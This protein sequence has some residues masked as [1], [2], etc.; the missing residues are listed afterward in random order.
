MFIYSKI[1]LMMIEVANIFDFMNK[2]YS[3]IT[4]EIIVKIVMYTIFKA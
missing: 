4:T 1:L 2:Y 3:F